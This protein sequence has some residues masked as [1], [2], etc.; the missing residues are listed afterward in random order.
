MTD[1]MTPESRREYAKRVNDAGNY[2][3]VLFAKA[4]RPDR[5][6]RSDEEQLEYLSES[7]ARRFKRKTLGRFRSKTIKTLEEVAQL[8]VDMNM[9]PT[10]EEARKTVPIIVEA[11]KLCSIERGGLKYISFNEVK[12]LSGDVTYRITAQDFDDD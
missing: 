8:L 10:I 1:E 2:L 12:N 4:G 5:K 7:G 3:K 11:N 6:Y 9:V